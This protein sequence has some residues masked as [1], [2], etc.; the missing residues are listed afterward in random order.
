MAAGTATATTVTVVIPTA[1]TAASSLGTVTVQGDLNVTVTAPTAL[2]VSIGS[3]VLPKTVVVTG[4]S[5]T[6]SIA[7][8]LVWSAIDTSQTPNWTQIAA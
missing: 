7:T 3:V 5:A 1:A 4:V 8:T 2:A 6:G